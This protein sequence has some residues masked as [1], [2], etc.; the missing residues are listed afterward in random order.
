M[1]GG[2]L[3]IGTMALLDVVFS[4]SVAAWRGLVFT[5]VAGSS[6]VLLSGLPE[7]IFPGL[8]VLP[9]L[10]LKASLGPLSGAMV[11]VYLGQ[12]L[13]TAAEDRLVHHTIVWG[14]VAMVLTA[15]IV[16][17]LASLYSDS[18]SEEILMLA[19]AFNTL[20]VLLA[21]LTAVRAAMLGDTMARSMVLACLFLVLSVGGLYSH[22]LVPSYVDLLLEA[23]TAFSTVM[24]FLVMVGLGIRHNRRMHRLEQLAGLSHSHDAATGLPQGSVLLTKVDDAFW[25]SARLNTNCTVIC[26]HLNNLYELNEIAGH[27]VDQK[28]L[29]A[30]AA[31][32]RRAVGF[33]CVVGLHHPRCF[34]VVLS[35]I[36]QVRAG[37]DITDRLLAL[38][39]K[40]LEVEGINGIPH[41]FSPQFNLGAVTVHAADAVPV[42]VID[43][44]EQQALAV[45]RE[46]R[47]GLPTT[48]SP[49]GRS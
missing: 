5:A 28:I 46:Q 10:I 25:R 30:M 39:C 24:F 9:V 7:S 21:T 19:A 31:R 34:V 23:A 11:L 2:L 17:V 6:C 32:I 49:L 4:R 38:M 40:P 43:A 3:T 13:G 35:A 27:S 14:S 16:T 48:G 26:L 42:Q 12:W 41:I 44:A 36:T 1:L 8:P 37:N 29:S 33:R 47:A 20:S 22:Q 18:Q 15:V 45:L